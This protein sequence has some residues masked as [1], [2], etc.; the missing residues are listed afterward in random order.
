LLNYIFGDEK[1]PVD[2]DL[3][4]RRAIGDKDL[5]HL[6]MNGVPG[7]LGMPVTTKLGMGGMFSVVPFDSVDLKNKAGL[8]ETVLAMSGPFLGGMLPDGVNALN[9]MRQG[10]YYK[11]TEML[12]P[13]LVRNGMKSYRQATEGVTNTK[14][15]VLLR[16]DE[17]SEADTMLQALGFSSTHL[18]DR[19]FT[20]NVVM[21]YE[22]YYKDRMDRVT[23]KYVKAFREGDTEGMR[24]ARDQFM[25]YQKAQREAGLLPTPI[26]SMYKAPSEQI[27]R[28]AKTIGGVQWDKHNLRVVKELSGE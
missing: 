25:E 2:A 10:E 5:A 4:L 3:A 18:N 1:T 22:E 27:K 11:A 13:S 24:D 19:T 20:Q 6:I 26:S 15:D 7:L 14:G 12:M 17:L 16:P 9:K 8:G 28:Q 21:E 23:H